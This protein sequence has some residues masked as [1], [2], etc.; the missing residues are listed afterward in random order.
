MKFI[1]VK[2]GKT[3]EKYDGL[4]STWVYDNPEDLKLDLEREHNAHSSAFRVFDELC[5]FGSSGDYRVVGTG[6]NT[7]LLIFISEGVI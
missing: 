5:M 6:D 4:I 7:N 1:L 3:G 2:A